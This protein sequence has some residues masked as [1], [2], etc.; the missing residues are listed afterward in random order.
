MDRDW[1][2]LVE[3]RAAL[4]IPALFQEDAVVRQ[5]PLFS[6]FPTYTNS[7]KCRLQ[8]LGLKVELLGF[9]PHNRCWLIPCI[10]A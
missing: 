2:A 6:S 5:L 4:G 10:K 7:H 1:D 3:A 9:H 8:S